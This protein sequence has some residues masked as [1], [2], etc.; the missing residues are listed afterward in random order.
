MD[1]LGANVEISGMRS[2]GSQPRLNE[3]NIYKTQADDE[4]KSSVRL[5][6]Q[7]SD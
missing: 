4:G 5:T 1:G 7:L 2:E 6:F 3:G